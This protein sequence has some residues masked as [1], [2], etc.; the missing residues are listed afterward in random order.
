MKNTVTYVIFSSI[1]PVE[2]KRKAKSRHK[3]HMNSWL[4]GWCQCE[5]FSFYENGTFY[6]DYDLLERKGIYLSRRD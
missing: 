5:G 6:E 2:G 4:H 3:M 1:L